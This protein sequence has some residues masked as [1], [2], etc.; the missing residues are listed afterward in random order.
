MTTRATP[1]ELRA[2]EEADINTQQAS[3][4]ELP[5]IREVKDTLDDTR[6][7]DEI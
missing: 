2:A 1:E 6:F 4:E 5:R 7:M 3:M